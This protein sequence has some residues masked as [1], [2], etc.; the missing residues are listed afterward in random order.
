MKVSNALFGMLY[1][2]K[3]KLCYKTKEYQNEKEIIQIADIPNWSNIQKILIGEKIDKRNQLAIPNIPLKL[4][5]IMEK[6]PGTGHTKRKNMLDIFAIKILDEKTKQNLVE[7]L[8]GNFTH[9]KEFIIQILDNTHKQQYHTTNQN[10]KIESINKEILWHVLFELQGFS[11]LKSNIDDLALY[12]LKTSEREM[13]N[14]FFVPAEFHNFILNL[15]EPRKQDDI[16]LPYDGARA[17][18]LTKKYL[19]KHHKAK[20]FENLL[21]IEHN[22]DSFSFLKTFSSFSKNSLNILNADP[23]QFDFNK[24][25]DLI[26]S[27]PPLH[28]KEI[29]TATSKK[30]KNNFLLNFIAKM[31][32]ILKN[33]GKLAI[34]VPN[35][36]LFDESST[37]TQF[38]NE[39][40]NKCKIHAIIQPPIG[41]LTHPHSPSLALIILEKTEDKAK[42][43]YP[44]FMSEIPKSE[45][46]MRRLDQRFFDSIL[47]NYKTLQEKNSIKETPTSCSF[48]INSNK[49]V[50]NGWTIADKIP[51]SDY[52]STIISNP[53]KLCQ[54]AELFTGPK[55]QSK[56]ILGEQIPCINIHN[57]QDGQIKKDMETIKRWKGSI[58]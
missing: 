42:T 6:I 18:I 57:L 25:F 43:N 53:I 47:T 20:N 8:T 21:T 36:F 32:D 30:Y 9:D 15:V 48:S 33:N 58:L 19:A 27:L 28:L 51:K 16:L 2:G 45:K 37:Y 10:E 41:S 23:M 55:I 17:T 34:I 7:K 1:N 56:K 40:L 3:E 35:S 31:L 14:E 49:L 13:N 38:K 50:E 11:L 24:K 39:L 46:Y 54:I 52:S 5:S 4:D 44:I 22:P 26:I 29:Y 12:L